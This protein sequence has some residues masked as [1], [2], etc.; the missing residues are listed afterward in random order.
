ALRFPDGLP[1]QTA[2]DLEN[3]M[4]RWASSTCESPAPFKKRSTQNNRFDWARRKTP[5]A[6]VRKSSQ[7][8]TRHDRSCRTWLGARAC[9]LAGFSEVFD[10]AIEKTITAGRRPRRSRWW[11][12]IETP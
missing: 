4:A 7:S 6:T 2:A 3:T 11:R 10:T 9:H 8:R 5:S 1:Y 12:G